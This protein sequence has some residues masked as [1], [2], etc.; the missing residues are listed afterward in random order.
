MIQML[1]VSMPDASGGRSLLKG[2][3][4]PGFHASRASQYSSC[5]V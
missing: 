5:P 2:Q 3:R 1:A 4:Y